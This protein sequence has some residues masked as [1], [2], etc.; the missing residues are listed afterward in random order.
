MHYWYSIFVIILAALALPA[1]SRGGSETDAAEAPIVEQVTQ[2][3][4]ELPTSAPPS[5][6]ESMT[7]DTQE[8]APVEP[9]REVST[10]P[11]DVQLA[12]VA[13]GFTS[14]V[15]MAVANDGS[16][17]LYII[18]QNG[19]VEKVAPD[20][21]RLGT[22]LD[23]SRLMVRL[24]PAYDERGLLGLAFHPNYAENG[25]VFAYFSVPDSD[26][27]HVGRVSEFTAIDGVADVATEAV[28]LEVDQPFGNHNG[29]QLSFG[30]DGLL[31]LGLGDGGSAGDPEQNSQDVDTLLG[32]IVRIDVD[33]AVPYAVPASNP[34]TDGSG[35][36]ELYAY[37]MR[38]PYRFSFDS[39]TGDLWV[40][41]VGQNA[42]EEVNIVQAGGNYGWP[43]RE[44]T[45]C[46][47]EANRNA[48]LD[49]CANIDEMGNPLLDPVLEYDHGVGI[50]VIGGYVYRGDQIDNLYGR[51][52]FGDWSGVLFVGTPANNQWSWDYMTINGEIGVG[53]QVLGF[54]E[55]EVGALYVLTSNRSSPTGQSGNVWRVAQS[56]NQ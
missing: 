41:D 31:Y 28:I 7:G 21:T 17:T 44:A 11:V 25:R 24:N 52:V 38:N 51:Y 9:V 8:V 50:S 48:P 49:A 23:V 53:A 29:G 22:F 42:F 34:F 3:T 15:G 40:A 6:N 16:N 19:T 39:L 30:P 13:D 45:S 37:G 14:P 46:Y 1:C 33:A 26:A 32:G 20:G 27:Q 18:E 54:G 35:T 47:N 56:V 10:E 5:T 12:L 4:A 36:P 2:T 55:D 43:I